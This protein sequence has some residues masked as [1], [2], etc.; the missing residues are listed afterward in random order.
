MREHKLSKCHLHCQNWKYIFWNSVKSWKVGEVWQMLNKSFQNFGEKM[1]NVCKTNLVWTGAKVRKDI[2]KRKYFEKRNILWNAWK[3][4]TRLWKFQILWIY[5]DT[6]ASVSTC[7]IRLRNSRERALLNL[8]LIFSHLFTS[9][10]IWVQIWHLAHQ[11][12][13]LTPWKMYS[14][15][16]N[17][18]RRVFIDLQLESAHPRNKY[19]PL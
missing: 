13:H 18:W 1:A 12:P 7:N 9:C 6:A 5:K 19:L 10:R 3:A 8:T 14:E 15:R 17:T 16:K 11:F 4:Q 2:P